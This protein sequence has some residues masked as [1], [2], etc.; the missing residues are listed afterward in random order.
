MAT[1]FFRFVGAGL[2]A[3]VIAAQLA[4]P[5]TPTVPVRDNSRERPMATEFTPTPSPTPIGL[6]GN[7]TGGTCG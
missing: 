2:L 5:T 3:L 4:S 6:G 1:K 7:C